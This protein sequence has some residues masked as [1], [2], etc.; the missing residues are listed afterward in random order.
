MNNLLS[1]PI[2]DRLLRRLVSFLAQEADMMTG[3]NDPAQEAE[4]NA[5]LIL[6]RSLDRETDGE[7]RSSRDLRVPEALADAYHAYSS[8][9]R[10]DDA[11]SAWR[12]FRALCREQNQD[13]EEIARQLNPWRKF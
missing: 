6:L 7:F 3:G 12:T 11:I 8:A 13:P 9:E 1:T 4:P 10:A 5:A 2:S